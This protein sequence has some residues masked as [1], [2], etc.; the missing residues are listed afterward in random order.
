MHGEKARIYIQQLCTNT[1]CS[2]EDLPGL[3]MI[4]TDAEKKCRSSILS[5][6][7]DDDDDDD[8]DDIQNQFY[9]KVYNF[10]LYFKFAT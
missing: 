2:Q 6:Y 9:Y 7:D 4:G 10:C 5:T 3:M 8:N 1:G